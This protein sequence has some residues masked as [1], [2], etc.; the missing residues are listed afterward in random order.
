[1]LFSWEKLIWGAIFYFNGRQIS[2]SRRGLAFIRCLKMEQFLEGSAPLRL[3]GKL[4]QKRIF[5]FVT[6]LI[7][8][9]VSIPL[10]I[11]SFKER[12]H[13]L[14]LK[15]LL[16]ASWRNLPWKKFVPTFTYWGMF[17]LYHIRPS[18]LR[19]ANANSIFGGSLSLSSWIR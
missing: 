10:R 3:C 11:S 18:S 4:I 15:K 16:I 14:G 9:N 1:M 12:F 6:L 5:L 19:A 7:L 13:Y 17:F 2:V 8:A